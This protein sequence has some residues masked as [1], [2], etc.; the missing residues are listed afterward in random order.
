MPAYSKCTV[1][2]LRDLCDSRGIDHRGLLKHQLIEALCADD[3]SAPVDADDNG[4]MMPIEDDIVSGGPESPELHDVFSEVGESPT[5]QVMSE[6]VRL[7]L[8]QLEIEKTK[9]EKCKLQPST[10]QERV[11]F[12]PR[13]AHLPV[14]AENGDPLAFFECFEK[15]LQLNGVRESDYAKLL[16]S[17]LNERAKRVFAALSYEQCLDYCFVKSQI[18]A[19]FRAS[20]G[21]YLDKFR[22]IRRSGSENQKMFVGRLT[23]TFSYY[24][25]AGELKTLNDLKEALILE[26]FFATLDG[27]TKQFVKNNCPKNS[28]EAAQL[29]DLYFENRTTSHKFPVNNRSK[30]P[31]VETENRA[32]SNGVND[33][34]K[35]AVPQPARTEFARSKNACFICNSLDHRQAQCPLK[36]ENSGANR[37]TF[38]RKMTKEPV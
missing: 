5:H 2:Q 29:A 26:Q 6:A 21:S 7:K 27:A 22:S 17:H 24:L 10:P 23:E 8:I 37:P 11:G 1:V 15:T 12:R 35:A 13:E 30:V 14:M 34:N 18:I 31:N 36:A 9:L 16:P 25:E 33:T 20:A 3:V 28:L 32:T 38:G 19:S 4:E